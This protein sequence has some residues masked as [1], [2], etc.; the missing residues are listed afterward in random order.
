VYLKRP[1]I[2]PPAS[3]LTAYVS[4]ESI[5][6]RIVMSGAAE[7]GIQVFA[8]R[9]GGIQRSSGYQ[10]QVLRYVLLSDALKANLLL[11]SPASSSQIFGTRNLSRAKKPEICPGTNS[12]Y[13][14]PLIGYRFAAILG[15]AILFIVSSIDYPDNGSVLIT[16]QFLILAT[17][18]PFAFRRRLVIKIPES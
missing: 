8:V 6:V 2:S 15:K 18:S 9:S 17:H 10:I 7:P 16:R 4:R 12:K 5:T 1:T 3:S 11:I 14:P 13:P